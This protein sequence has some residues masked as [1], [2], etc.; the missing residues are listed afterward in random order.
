MNSIFKC[1]NMTR[2]K[3]KE[4]NIE[5]FLDDFRIGKYFLDRNLTTKGKKS[6][7]WN[8]LR[9]ITSVHQKTKGAKI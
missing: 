1:E 4:K 5:I 8:A 2:K 6:F 9:L 7:Y 3:S